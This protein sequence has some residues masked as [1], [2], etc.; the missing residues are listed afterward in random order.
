MGLVGMVE[1]YLLCAAI[2]VSLRKT[3][4][5]QIVRVMFMSTDSLWKEKLDDI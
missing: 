3:T 1:F 5:A 2:E 4:H